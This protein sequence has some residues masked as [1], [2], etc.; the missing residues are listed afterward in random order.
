MSGG[1]GCIISSVLSHRSKNLKWQTSVAAL[2]QLSFIGQ[3][4]K[5]TPLK[6]EGGPTQKERPQSVLASSFLFIHLLLPLSLPYANWGRQEGGM[7]VSPE[8]L[9]PVCGFSSVPF[10]HAF[11]FLCLLATAILDSFFLF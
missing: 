2:L 6:H 5:S 10:S 11:L 9:T 7:F 1:W 8:A 4:K 3:A